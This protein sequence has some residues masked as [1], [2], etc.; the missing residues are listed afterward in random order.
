MSWYL[1][2]VH[3]EATATT[4]A[5]SEFAAIRL[6]NDIIAE[7]QQ[8]S[9]GNLLSRD[10]AG[11]AVDIAGDLAI[12]GVPFK[13]GPGF[14]GDIGT[15]Y[16][17]RYNGV[18]WVQI[19]QLDP[20]DLRDRDNYGASVAVDGD[21]VAIGAY[22][23][24]IGRGAVYVWQD[25]DGIW[26]LIDKLTA[27]SAN[28]IEWFGWALDLDG[29]QLVVGATRRD[30]GATDAGAVF[31]FERNGGGWMYSETLG[32]ASPVGSLEL[33]YD[34]A[35]DG[36]TLVVGSGPSFDR[37]EIFRKVGGS[38][39][40]DTLLSD[41]G[42]GGLGSNFGF[43]V[44]VN[45][46]KAVI[47]A[48]LYDAATNGGPSRIDAGAVYVYERDLGGWIETAVLTGDETEAG[49]RLGQSVD[50][51]GDLIAAGSHRFDLPTGGGS[52]EWESGG[53]FL[54]SRNGGVWQQ[55]GI[56]GASDAHIQDN[57]GDAVAM[58]QDWIIAGAPKA[59]YRLDGRIDFDVGRIYLF[60]NPNQGG[61]CGDANGNG[62]TDI[63][64]ALETARFAA[65]LI[66]AVANPA[67]ADV[68][69]NGLINIVDALLIARHA[70][71]L[72]TPLT[73]FDAAGQHIAGQPGVRAEA[74]A[75]ECLLMEGA[76]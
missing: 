65:G 58:D 30:L 40:A 22:N 28:A 55:A 47:G 24:A 35:L 17:Y 18:Q 43:S 51:A 19:Q 63:V 75:R 12:V 44:G 62:N 23:H 29:D 31:V 68:D 32:S 5:A 26:T 70:A 74:L 67:A 6:A 7:T 1:V 25:V 21:T 61:V 14:S 8:L 15:A 13:V 34:V 36:D 56:L 50:L 46:D 49:D 42:G 69:R 72:A 9:R 4:T 53:V 71:G 45:G 57:L 2:P 64:D 3:A 10:E 11:R 39:I 52:S 33:G 38:W 73:C 20:G 60:S 16:L 48:P 41:P 59:D 54:F 27:P 37:A 66:A 76:A